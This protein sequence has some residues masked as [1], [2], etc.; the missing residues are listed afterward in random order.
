MNN[1]LTK[2]IFMAATFFVALSVQA[3]EDQKIRTLFN[4]GG[5]RSNGGYGGVTVAYT[6]IENAD[7]IT[8]GGQ[9]AWLI[10]HQ[11]GI[12]LAGTGFISER[13]FDATLDNRYLTTGGY[14]G[15]LLEFIAMPHSP[16]HLSFPLVVGAG[17]LTYVES[18]RDFDFYDSE[19]SQAFFV[20]EPGVDVEFNLLP[21]IRLGVGLKYRVTSDI[22]LSYRDSGAAILDRDALTGF[23]TAFS[24]KFGKF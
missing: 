17:G 20:V 19:D 12:G 11:F 8:V 3:Q 18:R 10:N 22:E 24:L 6:Q 21:F 14:G 2:A 4:N 23:S 1:K 5:I 9:G 15:L 16:I 13:R 7:A